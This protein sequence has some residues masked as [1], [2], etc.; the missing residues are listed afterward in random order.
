MPYVTDAVVVEITSDFDPFG[1]EYVKVSLGY[2]LPIPRPPGVETIYPPPPK[3]ITYKHAIHIIIPKEKWV[4]QYTMW[5]SFKVTV[6]DD[7][8]VEI[9]RE[10]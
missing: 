6:E 3:P 9:R 5:Q 4:G 8:R 1:G 10:E 7:G 2:R